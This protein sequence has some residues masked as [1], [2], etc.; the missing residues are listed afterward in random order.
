MTPS[1]DDGVS[2]AGVQNS[3]NQTFTLP[4]TPNPPSSLK[5]YYNGILQDQGVDYTLSG[6][7]VT[8]TYV[9]PTPTDE[10]IAWYRY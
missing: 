4:D 5:L 1:F 10:Q 3:V 8:Y 7:T 9:K 6:D 2:L